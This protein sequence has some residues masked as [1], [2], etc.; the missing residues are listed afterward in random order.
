MPRESRVEP[1]YLIVIDKDDGRFSVEGPMTGTRPSWW[2]RNQGDRS[3]A[4]RQADQLLRTQLETG[5][6]GIPGG[7][8]RPARSSTCEG[9]RAN[10][11]PTVAGRGKPSASRGAV[12][13]DKESKSESS[14]GR[15]SRKA[16]GGRENGAA[17]RASAGQGSSR[18][19]GCK[20]R[21]RSSEGPEI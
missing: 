10:A 19:G 14:E 17:A 6:N 20:W 7:R 3:D 11:F 5:F 8:C 16:S 2:L 9:G 15:R 12:Q 13:D 18:Q 4:P 21:R 1:F